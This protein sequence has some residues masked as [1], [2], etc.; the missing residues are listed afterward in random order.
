MQYPEGYLEALA[1]REREK[2]NS[3]REEEEQQEGGFA[4]PRTGKGKWKRKS[5][6]G[7]PSR[8]GSPRRTSKKTKV[9]PYS[10]TAQQSSLIREDKSNAKLWNEVLASLKDRPAS[11]SPFQ[12]FLSK[13]EETF[14]CICCQELVFRPITTVCQHNVCKDCL[15]RSFRAQVFSCPACR[16]DLG[17]SYAMQVNQPLQTVLNQLFPGYGNGR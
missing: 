13:V 6:G 17:R 9:E 12:L 10:L 7:G 4:S 2:E 8:A 11:G 1:N 5:A 15:D 3:K 14:Q 16:Y